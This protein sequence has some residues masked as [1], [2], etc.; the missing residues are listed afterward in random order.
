MKDKE[1]FEILQFIQDLKAGKTVLDESF[2]NLLSPA[3]QKVAD[4]QYTSIFIAQKAAAFLCELK[5]AKVLDLGSG[6][7]KFCL[8]AALEHSNDITGVEFRKSQVEEANALKDKFK[9]EN[10][11]F[12]C[13]DMKNI[14]FE[15][16]DSFYIFNPFFEH[17]VAQ[18]RMDNEIE[19]A[20]NS[21]SLYVDLLYKK[22]NSLSSG[23]RIAAFHVPQAQ[24]PS[25]FKVVQSLFTGQMVFYKN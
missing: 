23:K 1:D 18:A 9:V 15:L 13:E 22:L 2:D 16:Y 17:K 11:H 8:I 4:Q 14:D 19:Y 25:Q 7:G 3:F 6:T 10:V 20:V 24:I 21:H 12:L 5:S